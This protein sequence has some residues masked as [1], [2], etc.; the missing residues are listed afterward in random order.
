VGGTDKMGAYMPA[1]ANRTYAYLGQNHFSFDNW[2]KAVRLGNTFVTSGPLLFFHAEGH[3]PG[4]EIT[5][6]PGG[7]TL[8]VHA[9][10]KSFVPIHR[11]DIVLNGQVVASREHREGVRE[12]SLKEKVRVKGPAWLAARCG[13]LTGCTTRWNFRISAHTS[14]VYLCVAGQELFSAPVA[15]YMLTLIDGAQSW[16]ESLAIQPDPERL[17]RVRKVFEHARAKLHSRLHQHGIEH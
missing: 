6:P 17:E 3:P 11:M 14:P 15:S 12:M 1:G 16:V 7:G 13:S 9:E 10:A 5:L 8:E 4:S 2:A